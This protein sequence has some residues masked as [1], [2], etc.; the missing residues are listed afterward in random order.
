MRVRPVE[1]FALRGPPTRAALGNRSR[2]EIERVCIA[3]VLGSSEERV[4]FK[5]LASRF[6]SVSA[7]WL[8]GIAPGRSLE[9]VIGK[10]DF[11]IFSREH[12]EEAFADEQRVIATGEPMLTK[13]ERETFRDRPGVWVQTMKQPLFDADGR[14]VGTW[15]VS[16][17][18]TAQVEAEQALSATLDRLDASDRE[19]RL[20]F[21]HN[22]LP[23]LV[24]DRLTLAIVAANDTFVSSYGYSHDELLSM[25]ITD[26]H[27]A[28]DV[29]ILRAFLA[30]NP[31][32][33]RAEIRQPAPGYTW[34]HR[35]KDGTVVDVEITSADL[36]AGAARDHRIAVCNDVTAR[37]RAIAELEVARDRLRASEE[38]YRMLFERNPQPML[39]HD[40]ETLQIVAASD[41]LVAGYGYSRDELL[42]MTILDLQPPEDVARLRAY[43]AA[44]PEGTRPSGGPQGW[45]HR[46]KDGTVVDVEVASDNVD[47]DGRDCRI[48]LFTDVTER[49]RAVSELAVAR[50]EAIK[51]SNTKSAFLAN[52]SHEIRTPMNGV[53]GMTELLLG[54]DLDQEQR[55]LAEQATQA[56]QQLLAVINDILDVSK[57]EAGRLE[58]DPADFDLHALIEQA[59]SLTRVAVRERGLRVELR[60]D[61]AVPEQ[62]HGDAGRIRQILTNL[63]SN[64]A[65]FTSA[66]EI[67]VRVATNAAER[68]RIE[69]ADTGIGIDPAVL[70]AMFE[71]FTQADSST[72][73]VYGGTGLGLTISTQLAA[74]MG[75]TIGAHSEP[76]RGSTFWFELPLHHAHGAAGAGAAAPAPPDS[77]V[78]AA[79]AADDRPAVL[80]VEDNPV[81]QI[82][83]VRNLERCGF[84]ADVAADGSQALDALDA[85]HYDAILM[86]CQMPVMNGYDTAIEIRRRERA[87][88]RHVPIIAMTASAMTG[89]RDLCLQAGMDDYITKP[90][91]AQKLTE[92][93]ERWT[94]H[95]QPA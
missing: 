83:A 76:G 68:V 64:A 1:R 25:A 28:D 13:L 50:D 31:G 65:K 16:R 52:M 41:S 82:I 51:A 10:T 46:R 48:V 66:G 37:N 78:T 87:T 40:R 74:L 19:H 53:I 42:Q 34:R 2:E 35:H 7:G 33:E 43:L 89:D 85:K 47:L 93:L 22:P 94:A 29:E 81:N 24:Y 54:T 15:G 92:T 58:L 73:R 72:T 9:W 18:V 45:R 8:A 17:D 63:L 84:R 30:A 36:P 23:M 39:A 90:V 79:G 44:T 57:I 14:I 91:Q 62:V 49:N 71:P 38:R 55:F 59:C 11:D 3:N 32:S 4:F 80:V 6:L 20:R 67:A 21:E 12:A 86:D 60:I 5:D 27:V 70:G 61:A 69:V 95:A 26:L 75:G 88:G 77:A 56:G